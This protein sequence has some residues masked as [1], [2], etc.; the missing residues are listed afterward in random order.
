VFKIAVKYKVHV[1]CRVR[2]V[3]QSMHRFNC[4]IVV[5]FII[6][7]LIFTQALKLMPS[8]TTSEEFENAGLALKTH[9]MFSVP[10]IPGKFENTTITGHF[11]FAFE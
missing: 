5:K 2:N 3:K 9:Q 7:V 6:I 11:E 1:I 4:I 10:S 8:P